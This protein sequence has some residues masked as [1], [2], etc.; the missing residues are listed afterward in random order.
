MFRG[1]MGTWLHPFPLH[2]LQSYR[3]NTCSVRLNLKASGAPGDPY[4]A[5]RPLLV[6]DQRGRSTTCGRG[7]PL[8]VCAVA[9]LGVLE[10]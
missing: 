1:V 6:A 10:F 2:A 3:G 9:Q 7:Y 8:W 4:V 5:I